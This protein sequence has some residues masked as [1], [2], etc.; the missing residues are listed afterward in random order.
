MR[1]RRFKSFSVVFIVSVWTG[2]TIWKRSCGRNTFIA[3]SVKWKRKT[4]SCGRGLRP[5]SN[6]AFRSDR[7]QCKWAITTVLC[8]RN[9]TFQT[10]VIDTALLRELNDKWNTRQVYLVFSWRNPAVYQDRMVVSSVICSS[11]AVS[12]LW[13]TVS[14]GPSTV[15]CSCHP[16][17]P[18]EQQIVLAAPTYEK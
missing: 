6:A 14:T 8:D 16:R 2:K 18:T 3:F 13:Q 10:D 1:S 11:A 15:S 17:L 5:V 9:A 12:V 4:H 7:I